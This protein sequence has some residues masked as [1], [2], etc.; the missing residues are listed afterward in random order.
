MKSFIIKLHILW[1]SV[2]TVGQWSSGIFG[3]Q[4]NCV[5]HDYPNGRPLVNQYCLGQ[6]AYTL[7]WCNRNQYMMIFILKYALYAL[8]VCIISYYFLTLFKP[9]FFGSLVTR[10]GGQICPHPLKMGV[11]GG[12]FKKWVGTSY[13]TKIDVRHEDLQLSDT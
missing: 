8:W 11:M 7:W 6:G 2:V 9:A 13:L 3:S 4:I 1:F 5:S 10:G 12:R